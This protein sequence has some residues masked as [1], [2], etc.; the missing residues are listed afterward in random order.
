M[1]NNGGDAVTALQQGLRYAATDQ[2]RAFALAHLGHAEIRRGE[3]VQYNIAW[4]IDCRGWVAWCQS[5]LT[6]AQKHLQDAAALYHAIGMSSGVAMCKAELALVL[7]SAGELSR[8]VESAREAIALVRDTGD[9]M[10]LVLCLNYGSDGIHPARGDGSKIGS[11]TMQTLSFL[12]GQKG[13][14]I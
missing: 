1:L 10:M 2:E 5:D 9:Q 3:I 14:Q 4:T 11:S 8:T 13:R 7:R 6:T 12:P